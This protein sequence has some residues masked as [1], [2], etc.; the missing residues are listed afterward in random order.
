MV[1]LRKQ[2]KSK[3]K[4]ET[5]LPDE[6]ILEL[7]WTRDER[8][9]QAT[10]TKYGTY[11]CR[12]ANN[13][14]ANEWDTEECV[15]DAYLE[16]WNAIPPHRPQSFLAFISQITRRNAMDRCKQLARGKRIPRDMLVCMDDMNETVSATSLQSETAGNELAALISDYLQG[17]SAR[18]RFI[19]MERYYAVESVENI[20]MELGVSASVVYKELKKIKH[21]L[22]DF[23]EKEGIT[24]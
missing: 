11:L 19:F 24:I 7:Y 1:Q 3:K 6:A 5:V 14:L 20:A 15:N 9:I 21:D 13:I 17:L 23:L 8:A 18:R 22:R 16:I 10:Q 2:K 12:L 4:E